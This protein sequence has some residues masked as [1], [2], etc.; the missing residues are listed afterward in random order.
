MI[1]AFIVFSVT[2]AVI[3]G[4]VVAFLYWRFGTGLA[5]RL[6]VMM[7]IGTLV[8]AFSS[9]FVALNGVT[10][11]AQII[12]AVIVSPI[13]LGIFYGVYRHVV[14]QLDHISSEL[15]TSTAQLAATAKQAAASAAQ[16]AAAVTEVSATVTELTETSKAATLSAQQVSQHGETAAAQGAQGAAAIGEARQVLSLIAQVNEIIEVVSGLA[17][18]SNFLAVNAGIEAAKAGE[19]GRG[20]AVVASEVR[21]LAEQSKQAAARIR[22]ALGAA[23]DG[24]R[25][26]DSVQGVV[27]ELAGLLEESSD[28]A[29]HISAATNQQAAGIRQI[30]DA[31][32]NMSE[33]SQNVAST[34]RQLEAAVGSLETLAQQARVYVTGKERRRA[35]A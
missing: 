14:K 18:Q 21:S 13:V 3:V 35:A 10:W 28:R 8:A 17:D 4:G 22:K 25:A 19:H 5:T 16:Q 29:R 7:T 6:I 26:L 11:T 32:S 2:A 31:M 20:F 30:S 1:H 27:G 12:N 24:R 15:I 34:A 23:Q 9:F 33:A